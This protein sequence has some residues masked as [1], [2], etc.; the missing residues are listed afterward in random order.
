MASNSTELRIVINADGTAAVNGV[1][2]VRD[3]VEDLGNV[4]KNIGNMLKAYLS[5]EFIKTAVTSLY[6]ASAALQAFEAR[7]QAAAGSALSGAAEMQYVADTAKKLSL[8]LNVARESYAQLLTLQQSGLVTQQQARLLL[9]GYAK[10]SVMV[11]AGNEQI[12]Q[13]M[14]GLAQALAMGVISTENAMQAM[15]PIAG[16]QKRVADALGMTMAEF[17]KA[18]EDQKITS[19]QF[20]DASI[21]AL[22]ALGQGADKMSNSLGSTM[23]RV[24]NEWTLLLEAIGNDSGFTEAV[25]S[26]LSSLENMLRDMTRLI[27]SGWLSD[28]FSAELSYIKKSLFDFDSLLTGFADRQFFDGI[29]KDLGELWKNFIKVFADFPEIVG[30][31]TVIAAS[32]IEQWLTN[33]KLAWSIAGGEF[34][35]S[36]E[37]M[38]KALSDAL[39]SMIVS[40]ANA[41]SKMAQS[42]GGFLSGTAEQLRALPE[43]M[44]MAGIADSFQAGANRIAQTSNSLIQSAELRR[45]ASNAES[46]AVIAGINA[47]LDAEADAAEIRKKAVE[48]AASA[49]VLAIK[50][51]TAER[52][53]EID[54]AQQKRRADEEARDAEI[55][56]AQEQMRASEAAKGNIQEVT[57]KTKEQIKAE[58]DLAEAQNEQ[59]QA[60]QLL[61][62]R[63]ALRKEQLMLLAQAQES[64]ASGQSSTMALSV[65]GTQTAMFEATIKS[66][67]DAYAALERYGEVVERI[68]K[69][70]DE[71]AKKG[72]PFTTDDAIAYAKQVNTELDQSS[73]KSIDAATKALHEKN[74]ELLNDIGLTLRSGDAYSDLAVKQDVATLAAR[75]FVATSK[76]QQTQALANYEA[77]RKYA[78]GLQL[79]KEVLSDGRDAFNEMRGPIGKYEDAMKK[80]AAAEKL[81]TDPAYIEQLKALGY[82]IEDARKYLE[83]YRLQAE[84]TAS[85]TA[86]AFK[87]ASDSIYGEWT[88]MFE[89]LFSGNTDAFKNFVDNL[90]NI[91]IKALAQMAAAA[92]AQPIIV[93]ILQTMGS[94]MGVP[95][96]QQSA[97]LNSIIPGA[98]GSVAGSVGSSLFGSVG[99]FLGG[100]VGSVVGGLGS[101]LGSTGMMAGGAMMGNLG[102]IGGT[103]QALTGGASMIMSGA[104]STGLGMIGAAAIPII[105]A[106]AAIAALSGAFGPTPHP[107]SL[108]V[109]GGYNDPKWG[110]GYMGKGGGGTYSD[111]GMEYG[112]SYGHTDPKDAMALRD[113]LIELDN[114]LTA[115]VPGVDLA[116]KS[117][118][119]FGQTAEGFIAGTHGLVSSQEEM[120]AWFVKDWVNA[121]EEVGAVSEMVNEAIQGISG[122]A[123]DLSAIFAVLMEMDTQGLLNRTVLDIGLAVKGGSEKI[124]EA[125]TAL[126]TITDYQSKDMAKAV[127]D[128]IFDA[129]ATSA[130]KAKRIAENYNKALSEMD[131]T[132]ATDIS[133]LATLVQQRYDLEIQ[134]ILEIKGYIDSLT[135]SIDSSLE[136]FETTGMTAQQ[137][138]DY[139]ALKS[140]QA[141]K[142]AMAATDPAVA[143]ALFAKSSEYAMNA[144]NTLTDEQKAQMKTGF[145]EFFTGLKTDSTEKLGGMQQ[146]IVDEHKDTA[147]EL[148]GILKTAGTAAAAAIA[149]AGEAIAY[150]GDGVATTLGSIRQKLV[151]QG[152]I[153]QLPGYASGGIVGGTWNGRSGRAGD[154]VITALTPG[155][156]VIPREQTM[157][158]MDLLRA[159]VAN[160]VSYAASGSLPRHPGDSSSKKIKGWGNQI[161]DEMEVNP[162]VP[163]AAEEIIAGNVVNTDYYYME[164]LNAGMIPGIAGG[165]D[166]QGWNGLTPEQFDY[167]QANY[168]RGDFDWGSGDSGPGKGGSGS[169]GSSGSS[170]NGLESFMKG[171]SRSLRDMD[172]TEYQRQ[173]QAITDTLEDN[174]EQA[175]A[176]GAS[177]AQLNQ[178]R[179]LARRQTEA[180]AQAERDKV[181]DF[182][183]SLNLDGTE[184]PEARMA[185]AQRQYD[186]AFAAAR[187]GLASADEVTAA[188]RSLLDESLSYYGSSENYQAILDAIRVGMGNL[189]FIPPPATEAAPVDGP[190][191]VTELKALVS[192]QS[193]GN[194][195]IIDKLSAMEERLAG[196][197][198]TARLE[199]AA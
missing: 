114:S 30:S 87:T 158:H 56:R 136:T 32:K 140:E 45:A 38:K 147:D 55:K 23:Q 197:E 85:V 89:E 46:D 157:R 37:S 96:A 6:E 58:N 49:S 120:T 130:E 100:A 129:T 105:G 168:A 107:S 143:A 50:A 171:I 73:L 177:E 150:A 135:D 25:A 84:I 183:D 67:D 34:K 124:K 86:Q 179:E 83:A 41:A 178:V 8:D 102:L 44:G 104:V 24:K 65:P 187:D 126:F 26:V 48:E 188:A 106:I 53:A 51:R 15:E 91:F 52:D 74:A 103:M 195:A 116:G 16:M 117:L 113:S 155:E 172:L 10:A 98:T 161:N 125:M 77:A 4:S 1:R 57:E 149:A 163:P 152:Y 110:P 159:I 156:A 5:F 146:D 121:A 112:Y 68:W 181:K 94:V 76:E 47:Q 54:A 31:F 165:T 92:L 42:L 198:S 93:P 82:S 173:F 196:I 192:V 63:E 111:S 62:A 60:A 64:L 35:I 12:K 72:I 141:R 142:D 175:T 154:T 186:E 127:D 199:A 160:D 182:L 108:A 134:R 43:F 109:A 174:I 9:E 190:Q 180:L 184:S 162:Y 27:K 169:G 185:E 33:L 18:M 133:N 7:F 97:I 81:L 151:D 75:N 193:A 122:S 13:S 17:K 29:A 22:D 101:M 19:Q 118:G 61:M 99:G 70:Q 40:V 3:E 14:A 132:N 119:A 128:A 139:W 167:Y 39:N 194:R 115:L 176:M 78:A 138:Y 131:W 170:S 144:W 20:A 11:G 80:A 21:K 28:A 69:M 145:T 189:S 36:W 90:K 153:A 191:T 148:D 95:G 166:P 164:Q 66:A 59:A 137:E 79:I 123:E 2:R 71:R 88:T